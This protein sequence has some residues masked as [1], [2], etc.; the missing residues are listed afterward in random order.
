[1]SDPAT[2]TPLMLDDVLAAQAVHA[3]VLYTETAPSLPGTL[4]AAALGIYDYL[5]QVVERIAAATE[6]NRLAMYVTIRCSEPWASPTPDDPDAASY[7]SDAARMQDQFYAG[8]CSEWPRADVAA[9]ETAP[10]ATDT[11]ILLL[12]GEADAQNPPSAA[13]V[14]AEVASNTTTVIAPGHGHGIAQFGCVSDLVAHFVDNGTIGDTDRACVATMDPPP[15]VLP[16][17]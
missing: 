5:E 14:I 2:G 17:S 11:P 10:P 15:F 8:A 4:R 7:L 3:L 6:V 13:S 1:V 9:D 12:V 16:P